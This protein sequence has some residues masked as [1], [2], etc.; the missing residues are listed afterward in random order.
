M[1]HNPRLASIPEASATSERAKIER[2]N[3]KEEE[4]L[5]SS[6]LWM[7]DGW[8]LTW[9][10]WHMLSRDERKSIAQ[11]H[12]YKHI[13]E[14]EEYM[15][16]QQ[17]YDDSNVVSQKPYANE[18]I[19]P[20]ETKDDTIEQDSKP[21]AQNADE[22]DGDQSDDNNDRNVRLEYY[23]SASSE[24]EDL[25]LEEL[26]LVGGK[27]L[28]LHDEILHQ[29]FR[30]LPVDAYATLALVSPHWKHLTRTE[31]V[32]KRLAERIYLVQ[33]KR[34]SLHVQRFGC[35][36]KML[37]NRP[38]VRAAGGC[39]VLKYSHIKKIQR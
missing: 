15:S 36:R 25:S 24:G 30:F 12:G 13:G 9:P 22:D 3:E 32:Y 6:P 33:S 23:R 37:E 19:Y 26:L 39:Y 18:L 34:K 28:I 8:H 16:L 31:S 10:I 38:R 11:R 7:E 17:A 14:F 21:P 2:D 5:G 20:K 27:I 29:I 35:Y 1:E 4:D